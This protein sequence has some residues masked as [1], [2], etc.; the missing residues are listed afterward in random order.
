[1]ESQNEIKIQSLN[2]NNNIK[3]Y[4][5]IELSFIKDVFRNYK[6]LFNL[7]DLE[8]IA[9]TNISFKKLYKMLRFI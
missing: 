2:K 1:M 5:I 9:F 8:G 4:N 7:F 6:K 3:K